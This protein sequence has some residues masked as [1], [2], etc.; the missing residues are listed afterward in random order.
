MSKNS[1]EIKACLAPTQVLS[2]SV[3]VCM[4]CPKSNATTTTTTPIS[5]TSTKKWSE[6]A[7]K[8]VTTIMD[9]FAKAGTFD[10]IGEPISQAQ[11]ALQAAELAQRAG[12]P[13]DVILAALL[14]DVGHMVG[15]MDPKLPAMSDVGTM[16]HEAV[17]ANFLRSLGLSEKICQLVLRHVDAK[18]YLCFMNKGYFAKLSEASKK[19][20]SYQGGPMDEAEAARFDDDPLKRTIILMR[21]WDEAAKRVNWTGPQLVAYADILRQHV[22]Q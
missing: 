18:R 22:V 3:T 9:M 8:A 21:T 17:G 2:S 5:P 13:A 7:D 1:Q 19:T 12:A 11:H 20:L 16:N 15:A 6:K 10:Y 4:N 14:H